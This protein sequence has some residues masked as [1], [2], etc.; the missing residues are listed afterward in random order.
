MRYRINPGYSGFM[1]GADAYGDMYYITQKQFRVLDSF[2]ET[3]KLRWYVMAKEINKEELFLLLFDVPT[4]K[5]QYWSLTSHHTSPRF[6]FAKILGFNSDSNELPITGFYSGATTNVNDNCSTAFSF[7]V[8]QISRIE[9]STDSGLSESSISDG[10]YDIVG[11]ESG[12][13][14]GAHCTEAFSNLY[15]GN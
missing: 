15:S 9:A 5:V 6:L 8:G 12:N 3:Y 10:N 13:G 1:T 2:S 14:H 4:S 7:R 11:I